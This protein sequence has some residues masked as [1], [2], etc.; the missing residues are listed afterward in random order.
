MRRAARALALTTAILSAA[1]TAPA[2]GASDAYVEVAYDIHW[3][4]V[5]GSDRILVYCEATSFPARSDD[6]PTQTGVTCSV[7]G[8]DVF[9][10]GPS[11]KAVAVATH[12]F[13]RPVTFCYS[14][15]ALFFD[16]DVYTY[17]RTAPRQCLVF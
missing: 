17:I 9:A 4:N 3:T 1:P 14:A 13:P 15:V 7:N 16:P 6:I 11:R 12:P 2:V 10:M 8:V 5:D